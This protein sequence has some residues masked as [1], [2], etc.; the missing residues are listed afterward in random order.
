[1]GDRDHLGSERAAQSADPRP[2]R[3]RRRPRRAHRRARSAGAARESLGGA[4]AVVRECRGGGA[5]GV[6]AAGVVLAGGAFTVGVAAACPVAL[7]AGVFGEALLRV[8]VAMAPPLLCL[9]VLFGVG[10]LIGLMGADYPDAARE[11]MSRVGS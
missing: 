7:G 2:H 11:W 10:L 3:R 9:G 6:G 5:R 4:R 8:V 1:M